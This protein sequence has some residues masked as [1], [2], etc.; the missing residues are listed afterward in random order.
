MYV[1]RYIFFHAGCCALGLFT[2]YWVI[3]G[4]EVYY[5]RRREG[6]CV[7]GVWRNCVEYR[8]L[9]WGKDMPDG[10]EKGSYRECTG[11]LLRICDRVY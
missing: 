4:S 11:R 7:E 10:R 1:S 9:I 5:F 8:I 3:P 2:I 6:R